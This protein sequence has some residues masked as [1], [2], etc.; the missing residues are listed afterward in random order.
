M[1]DLKKIKNNIWK[2]YVIQGMKWFLLA[3]PIL[4]PFYQSNGLSMQQ[5]LMLQGVF[6]VTAV[7]LEIPTGYVADLFGRKNTIVWGMFIWAAGWGLYSLTHS[8]EMFLVVEVML[9]LSSSLISG[10][11]SALLYDSLELLGDT[12]SYTKKEGNLSTIWN[13]SEGTASIIGAVLAVISLRFPIYCQAI[14]ALMTVP[15]ALSLKEPARKAIDVT[16][17]KLKKLFEAVKFALVDHSEIKWLTIYT[18]AVSCAGITFLWFIQP[19]FQVIGIPLAWFGVAWAALQFTS[20]FSSANAQKIEN[21]FGRRNL[22]ILM[23]PLSALAFLLLAVV[24]GY[25]SLIVMAIPYLI[26]GV[27]IPVLKDYINKLTPSDI[28]AT[29][30]SVNALVMRLMFAIIGPAIGFI[31]DSYSF[32]TAFFT[33]FIIFI[34]ISVVSLSRMKSLR[35]L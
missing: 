16:T 1:N 30:L 15:I 27:N 10:S 35:V 5:I 4:V 31:N 8:F 3:V 12:S 21:K 17:G 18:A 25:W 33:A 6:S 11:D 22:L 2:L 29:V 9:A 34:L 23:L 28:R 26:R 13:I 20:A 14:I 7:L 32:S 19:R 24:P